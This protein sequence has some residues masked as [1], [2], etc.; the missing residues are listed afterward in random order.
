MQVKE[1]IKAQFLALI[2]LE[3]D[4]DHTRQREEL[5]KKR[6]QQIKKQEAEVADAMEEEYAR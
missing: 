6:A 1:D 2:A 3:E 5:K 4:K